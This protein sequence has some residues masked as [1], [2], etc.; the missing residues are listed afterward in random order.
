MRTE[1]ESAVLLNLPVGIVHHHHR[2]PDHRS[3]GELRYEQVAEQCDASQRGRRSPHGPRG[4]RGAIQI[5]HHGQR[6]SFPVSAEPSRSKVFFPPFSSFSFFLSFLFLFFLSSSCFSFFLF[7]KTVYSFGP[8]RVYSHT[9]R[10]A[11][12]PADLFFFLNSPPPT[13]RSL[14]VA[15]ET[16]DVP[17]T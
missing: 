14:Q 13:S 8:V 6:L 16:S 7:F 12:H 4:Q 17:N 15:N 1:T 9:A 2:P 3:S 5:Q 10:G 11:G